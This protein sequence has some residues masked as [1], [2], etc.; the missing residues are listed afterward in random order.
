[1]KVV[2]YCVREIEIM[3]Y[4]ACF[5]SKPDNLTVDLLHRLDHTNVLEA[6]HK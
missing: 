2:L 3:T 1:M 5:N 4:T 6:V